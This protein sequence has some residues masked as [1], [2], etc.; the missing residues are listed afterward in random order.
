MIA[1]TTA[2][3]TGEH[4]KTVLKTLSSEI[5]ADEPLASGGQALGF[6]PGELLASA[7][8]ACTGIT[9]RMYADRK[10]WTLEEV[11]VHVQVRKDDTGTTTVFQR[12]ILLKGE[13]SEEEKIRLLHIANQC[14]V[15]RLLSNPVQ[16]LTSLI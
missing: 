4:Y 2:H 3:N 8:G 6:S 12:D 7:L 15:H 10:K 13:L 9:L 11:E 1:E 14:P 16:I 5:I